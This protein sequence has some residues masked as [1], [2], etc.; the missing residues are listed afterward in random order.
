VAEGAT[1]G[2]V[3]LAEVTTS[4]GDDGLSFDAVVCDEAGRVQLVMRGYHTSALP[5]AMPEE[6][7]QPLRDGLTGYQ[8]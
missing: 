6:I 3:A 7:W 4:R 1:D 2:A 5:G 8:P